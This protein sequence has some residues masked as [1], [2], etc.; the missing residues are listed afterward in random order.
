[1]FAKALAALRRCERL[2]SHFDKEDLNGFYKEAETLGCDGWSPA[3]IPEWLLFEIESN[4]TIR[5]RQAGVAH[6]MIE[7]QE[8]TVLQLNMGEG[9]T[10][11]ITPLIALRL[12]NGSEIPRI[13]V[14]KPLL[15]QSVNLLSQQ[16]GGLL[17]RPVYHI[18]FSRDTHTGET[19]ARTLQEIYDECL[20]RRGILIVLPEQLLSFRL[21][22]LDL[23]DGEPTIAH[24]L[25]ELEQRL[26]RT[27]RTII[28]ESDEVL[29]AKFQLVYTRGHQQ[30]MDGGSDRWEVVQYVLKEI[31]NQALILRD[32][33]QI[34][35]EV[36]QTGTRYPILRFLKTSTA[37]LLLEKVLGAIENGAI[38]GLS[39]SQFTAP[40]SESVMKFIRCM[41]VEENGEETVRR[42]FEGSLV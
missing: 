23:A 18:Q 33:E 26:Q 7:D 37:G 8:N 12:S 4:L 1:M 31:E 2:I 14:L 35:L 34:G 29:D 22:G 25:I 38:P 21:V 9:K 19:T 32:E 30:N 10:T 17:N 40:V 15:R 3:E 36:D 16:L 11:V 39:F 42:V 6:K 13:V 5:A 28:V 27:C 20:E 24:E 41:E